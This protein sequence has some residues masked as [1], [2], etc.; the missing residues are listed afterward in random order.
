MQSTASS[1]ILAVS[2]SSPSSAAATPTSGWT[3]LGCDNDSVGARTLTNPQ[4]GN[5]N[6][7][8][9]ELCQSQCKATGFIQSGVE[10]AGEHY[11]DNTFQN[12]RV[13]MTDSC[14]YS[15]AKS[16]SDVKACHVLLP[17]VLGL[18]QIGP[19]CSPPLPFLLSFLVSVVM[20]LGSVQW[21]GVGVL[22]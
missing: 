1:T 22:P 8:T 16:S 13:P 19:A 20:E 10:Y 9:V 11:Y 3:R 21:G 2:S 7:M 17:F 6:V 4:Y 14:N 18:V 15:V 5:K 12:Y